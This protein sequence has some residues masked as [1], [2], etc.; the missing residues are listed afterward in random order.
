MRHLTDEQLIQEELLW[1]Y[2]QSD[3]D[4]GIRS[5]W[6][7]MIQ[8][9]HQRQ[10]AW[11]DPYDTATLVAIKRRK[12]VEDCLSKL[13]FH[14]QRVLQVMY[15][16]NRIPPIITAVMGDSLAGPALCL[17]IDMSGADF[18]QLCIRMRHSTATDKDQTLMNQIRRDA[19][20]LR[21]DVIKAYKDAKRKRQ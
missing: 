5:N 4:C 15:G 7:A 19:R 8:V 17:E 18:V 9:M 11:S 20:T 6:T 1:Y 10:S 21:Q 14:Q 13:H 16:P 12:R 3:S 2:N